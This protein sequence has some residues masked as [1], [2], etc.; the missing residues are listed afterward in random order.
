MWPPALLFVTRPF[1]EAL[2]LKE[3]AELAAL[4]W[5][6]SE[7][8][9]IDRLANALPSDWHDPL[10]LAP[11]LALDPELAPQ[12]TFTFSL[13]PPEAA[14]ETLRAQAGPEPVQVLD[15]LQLNQA[16]ALPEAENE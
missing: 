9:V 1:T 13:P 6:V 5:A 14:R 11:A 8:P 2:P 10:P 4:Y 15:S 12:V 7:R 16:L 3:L